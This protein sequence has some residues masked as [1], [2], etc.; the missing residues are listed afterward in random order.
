MLVG[1]LQTAREQKQIGSE[2]GCDDLADALVGV[3]LSRRLTGRSAA[4]W[5]HAAIAAVVGR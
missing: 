3:Y 5:A 2:L 4:G 1:A